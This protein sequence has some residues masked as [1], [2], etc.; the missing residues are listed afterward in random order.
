LVSVERTFLHKEL[1]RKFVEPFLKIEL[2]AC[3][4]G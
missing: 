1:G 2:V 4:N 3:Y